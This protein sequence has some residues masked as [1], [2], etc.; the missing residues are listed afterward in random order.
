MILAGDIGGTKTHL[1]LFR[2]MNGGLA[3]VRGKIFPSREY[4]GLEAVIRKFLP[5]RKTAID[6]A[7]FGV[8]GPVLD[9]RCETTNLPWT[10]DAEPIAKTFG[11]P[12]VF[13][14]NDLEATAY[15]SLFLTDEDFHTLNP[16]RPQPHGNRAVI[17][18]GTGLGEAVL[19]W[20]GGGYR[21]SASEGGHTDFGPRGPI[22]IQLL[23]YL[24]KRFPHVSYERIVSGP[25]LL[26]IYQFMKDTGRVEEPEWLPGKMAVEDPAAVITEAALAGWSEICV[27]TVDL[28]VSIYGAEA[29]NL[30]LKSLATGGVS[31]GGG[32][33]PRIITKLLDGQFMKA[34]AD[35][36]RYASLLSPI[37]VRIILNE[38][39]GLL[40]A[41]WYAFN[42]F[43]PNRKTKR[44]RL[45]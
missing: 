21:A 5:T 9:G 10:I 30:A 42:A 43:L 13:L 34:F 33:A 20:D 4:A 37:P 25:G 6:C 16:G 14:L 2:K 15:G 45:I 32:I 39:V 26:N 12:G 3:R 19:F 40:G 27:K 28:F 36:G 22:E 11:I 17:A 29:G 8:A 38:T 23:E 31:L 41:A 7:C 35:K 24:L 18:A 1:A 44:R